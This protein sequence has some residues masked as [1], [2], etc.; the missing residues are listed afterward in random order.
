MGHK[1]NKH[2]G[3][4]MTNVLPSWLYNL[5]ADMDI[6]SKAVDDKLSNVKRWLDEATLI[7][8]IYNV[9]SSVLPGLMYLATM[10]N[11]PYSSLKIMDAIDYANEYGINVKSI[12]EGLGRLHKKYEVPN[13]VEP[14]L[15]DITKNPELYFLLS[16]ENQEKAL[17][18]AGYIKQHDSN[19]GLVKKAVGDRNYPIYQTVPDSIS[20]EKL[21]PIGNLHG[22]NSNWYGPKEA[23]LEHANDYSSTVYIDNNGNFYQAAWDLNDYG[24]HGG[25]TSSKLGDIL[26]RIGNPIVFRTGYQPI[27]SKEKA[28]FKVGIE[29]P[30]GN[31]FNYNVSPD[32]IFWENIEE[33]LDKTSNY[34][35]VM[36]EKYG[37]L[38][39]VII[40][41]KKSIKTVKGRHKK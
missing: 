17:K 25:S 2:E 10:R 26:D 6:N 37:L 12:A 23:M 15:Q 39:E 36:R 35:K 41:P 34:N 19:Y 5:M 9:T 22:G 16:R 33:K 14:Q 29:H 27:K 8:D 7:D 20:R 11:N 21:I 32:E 30:Y 40:T 31:L 38:P 3:D 28:T 18:Q 24:G 1:I 13:F 4:N